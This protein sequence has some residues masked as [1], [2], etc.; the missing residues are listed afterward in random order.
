MAASPQRRVLVDAR[1][2]STGRAGTRSTAP[3]RARRPPVH[4]SIPPCDGQ[5]RDH[6]G[7]DQAAQELDGELPGRRLCARRGGVAHLGQ[8]LRRGRRSTT[9]P[10]TN[11]A[12]VAART[13]RRSRSGMSGAPSGLAAAPRLTLTTPRREGQRPN[14]RPE[15]SRPPLPPLGRRRERRD[16]GLGAEPRPPRLYRP[17]RAASGGVARRLVHR[18]PQDQP[19]RAG[20]VRVGVA[21]VVAS[22]RARCRTRGRR[23][24]RSSCG[25]AARRSC[26]DR[27]SRGS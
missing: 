3:A 5:A 12:I 26:R 7:E 18:H 15:G 23:P 14:R 9:P 22:T 10:E 4:V 21:A 17:A 11:A 24:P 8:L 6:R 19:D 25:R 1:R 27:R 13:A 16:R 20:R 2:R